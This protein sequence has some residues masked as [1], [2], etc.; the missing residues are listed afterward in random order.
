[1]IIKYKL[2]DLAKDMNLPNKDV[3]MVLEPL[4]GQAR[5]HTTVLSEDELDFFFN[6]I[7]QQRQAKDL[8]AYFANDV[9]PEDKPKEEKKPEP[10]KRPEPQSQ[11][12]PQQDGKESKGQQQKQQTAQKQP[13]KPAQQEQSQ[14]QK[15]KWIT[16]RSG[17]GQFTLPLR[18][19]DICKS[20]TTK[21]RQIH[22]H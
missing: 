15:Q 13:Q 19:T 21:I 4:E 20:S 3:I 12:K 22:R 7:T 8:S 10:A 14:K 18:I 6:A 16:P 1:M 11:K 2:G 9:L 17:M 5:K